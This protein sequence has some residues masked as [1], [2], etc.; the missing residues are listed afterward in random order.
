MQD[1]CQILSLHATDSF[2]D[3]NKAGCAL[4]FNTENC[5]LVVQTQ[6]KSGIRAADT[7]TRYR[8]QGKSYRRAPAEALPKLA[9]LGFSAA[10]SFR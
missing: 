5:S 3:C 1:E 9:A 2:G 10:A 8:K 6:F 7:E 4:C